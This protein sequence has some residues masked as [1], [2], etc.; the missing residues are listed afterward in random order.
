MSP[1][2]NWP[3]DKNGWPRNRTEEA[4]SWPTSQISRPWGGLGQWYWK[5]GEEEWRSKK[6]PG[7]LAKAGICLEINAA[8]NFSRARIIYKFPRTWI[9]AHAYSP[10]PVPQP[11]P[12]KIASSNT[13]NQWMLPQTGSGVR[14]WGKDFAVVIKDLQTGRQSWIIQMVPKYHCMYFYKKGTEK[15]LTLEEK[16]T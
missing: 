5:E 14:E 12:V 11:H 10:H 16:A 3:Q 9:A 2:K 8:K 7:N 4:F 13:L 6:E 15:D 1:W